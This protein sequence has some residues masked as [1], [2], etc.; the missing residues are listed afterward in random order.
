MK[1]YEIAAVLNEEAWV[2]ISEDPDATEGIYFGQIGDMGW[3]FM[4]EYVVVEIWPECYHAL[5]NRSGISI[6]VRKLNQQEA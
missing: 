4:K 3:K 1:L 6:Y 5:G 2:W